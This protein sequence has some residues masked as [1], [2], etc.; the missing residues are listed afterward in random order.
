MNGIAPRVI[1]LAWGAAV[2]HAI[3][4]N[5]SS[6]PSSPALSTTPR[7]QE[8]VENFHQGQ[9]P[10]WPAQSISSSGWV[11]RRGP[12]GRV[13]TCAAPGGAGG[14][15]GRAPGPGRAPGAPRC[16]LGSPGGLRSTRGPGVRALSP[17]IAPGVKEAWATPA[18]GALALGPGAAP[19]R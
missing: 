18:Q 8:E 2:P 5:K 14:A 12:S 19:P 11:P 16:R 15:R 9:T 7:P 10:P 1:L 17:A 4:S 13:G 3:Y 6:E